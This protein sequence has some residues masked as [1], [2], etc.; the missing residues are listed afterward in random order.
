MLCMMIGVFLYCGESNS[1]TAFFP[2]SNNNSATAYMA[3]QIVNSPQY[4]RPI[5]A[6]PTTPQCNQ[7]Q[8]AWGDQCVKAWFA[9]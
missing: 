3:Q 1:P 6:A 8:V 5:P 9:K 7:N 4:V 2:Q